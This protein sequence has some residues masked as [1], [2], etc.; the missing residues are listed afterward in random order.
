[1]D[2]C[3][4]IINNQKLLSIQPGKVSRKLTRRKDKLTE[5]PVFG[6]QHSLLPEQA[7]PKCTVT[8]FG[9]ISPQ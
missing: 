4:Q 2:Y 9:S 5:C 3:G 6:H 7:L 1:L 8:R